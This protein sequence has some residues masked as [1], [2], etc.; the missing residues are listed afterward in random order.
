MN[1]N[2]EW[3]KILRYAWSI[4]LMFFAFLL[5]LVEAF[6]PI[7]EDYFSISDQDYFYRGIFALVA[8]VFSIGAI[9]ARLYAQ[10]AFSKELEG[11]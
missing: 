5:T 6:L 8:A 9:V 3:K 10:K 2:S 7:I 4:R 1:F 11:E